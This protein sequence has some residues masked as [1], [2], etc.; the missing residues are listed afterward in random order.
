VTRAIECALACG[1]ETQSGNRYRFRKLSPAFRKGLPGV[2][3][4]KVI[5]PVLS[6]GP[7]VVQRPKPP[8]MTPYLRRWRVRG[9]NAE[10]SDDHQERSAVSMLFG[11]FRENEVELPYVRIE[12]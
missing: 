7:G 9:A 8:G 1:L 10:G 6:D 12:M 4:A 3:I 2:A 11:F 5:D